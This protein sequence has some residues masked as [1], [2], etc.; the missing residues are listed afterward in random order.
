MD[1]ERIADMANGIR[2]IRT[3]EPPGEPPQAKEADFGS[4]AV[5][6]VCGCGA[7]GSCWAAVHRSELRWREVTR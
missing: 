2:E 7:Q 3:A 1:C 6:G 5:L 4:P